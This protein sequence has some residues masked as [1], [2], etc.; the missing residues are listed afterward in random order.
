MIPERCQTLAFEG[1]K[2][3]ISKAPKQQNTPKHRNAKGTD[4]PKAHQCAE[5][6]DAPKAPLNLKLHK[7]YIALNITCHMEESKTG[8]ERGKSPVCFKYEIGTEKTQTKGNKH[9]HN[10]K[11]TD[12][13]M[14]LESVVLLLLDSH[15]IR[16][17]LNSWIYIPS[18]N[19]NTTWPRKLYF[20]QS[21]E[22]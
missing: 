10:R 6:T 1:Q 18:I 13:E 16:N 12:K 20:P 5:S 17:T 3:A 11:H 21:I 2:V 4:T 19:V 9:Y 7:R 15:A 22:F 14:N 8:Y